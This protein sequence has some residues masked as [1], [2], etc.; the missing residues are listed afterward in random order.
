MQLLFSYGTLQNEKV[1]LETYGRRLTGIT[2]S[3]IGF[4]LNWVEITD[5]EVLRKSMQKFHPI[6]K[7]TGNDNDIVVGVAYE[8]TSEELLRTDKYEVNSYKRI[9]CELK[10]GRK[11][12]VYIQ[13]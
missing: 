4:S 9:L 11:A 13:K 8:I 7:Y 1:Q 6:L 10:S 3:L 5:L 12:Y 2:D